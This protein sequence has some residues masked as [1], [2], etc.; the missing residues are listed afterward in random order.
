VLLFVSSRRVVLKP[1]D[2]ALVEKNEMIYIETISG[3][4]E[5]HDV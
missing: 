3:F 2:L 5:K 1:P 4:D